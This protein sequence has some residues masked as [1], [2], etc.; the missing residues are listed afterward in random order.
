MMPKRTAKSCR[1]GAP[2]P[3]SSLREAAQATV[4]NKP[5]HREEHEVSR[6][7]IAQGEPD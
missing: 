7:T 3:A 6:K 5:G 4:S 1:S 2:M